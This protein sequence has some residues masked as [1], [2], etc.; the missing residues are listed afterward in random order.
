MLMHRI[1]LIAFI[2][3]VSVSYCEIFRPLSG[4]W[5]SEVSPVSFPHF[6][7]TLIT[8]LGN[9]IGGNGDTSVRLDEAYQQQKYESTFGQ[10]VYFIPE[11]IDV[12]TYSLTLEAPSFFVIYHHQGGITSVAG[13]I[14]TAVIVLC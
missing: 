3:C 1:L 14:Y 7:G 13:I 10:Q 6:G 11:A 8:F 4:G 5:V 12:G 2:L 9:N